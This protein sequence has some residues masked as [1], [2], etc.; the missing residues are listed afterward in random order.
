MGQVG[1]DWLDLFSKGNSKTPEAAWG[2][3]IRTTQK[4]RSFQP[5]SAP[6]QRI[7]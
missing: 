5:F 4:S 6:G 2:A 1:Y 3:V 7:L